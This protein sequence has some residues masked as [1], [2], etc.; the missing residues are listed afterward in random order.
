VA[1]HSDTFSQI[2][3]GALTQ[4]L[5]HERWANNKPLQQWYDC[6]QFDL[7]KIQP[8]LCDIT[9]T[10]V[11]FLQT[12]YM[13]LCDNRQGAFLSTWVHSVFSWVCVAP[14]LVFL[15]IFC[16]LSFF[17][18][19]FD[20]CI[21]WP[22]IDSFWLTIVLYDLWLT[23]SGW[24]LY[25]MTFDWQLLVDHCIIWP[26]IDSFWLPLWYLQIFLT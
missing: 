17:H 26:L 2:L 19:S 25:C 3:T 7:V 1:L 6:H 18:F 23:A 16:R 12:I 24:P 14:S 13:I 9:H 8:N 20:H 10:I 4:Y 22:L 21:I 5:L 11:S 15:V